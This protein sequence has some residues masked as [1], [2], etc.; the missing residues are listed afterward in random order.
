[1]SVVAERR[2]GRPAQ[3]S[4]LRDGGARARHLAAIIEG[5]IIP[6][7]LLAHGAPGTASTALERTNQR[8]LNIGEA[9][10]ARVADLSVAADAAP[11]LAYI[12]ELVARGLRAP[13][14]FVELI[15]PAARVLGRGWDVDRFDFVEVTLGLWRLQETVRRHAGPG[16]CGGGGGRSI[17]IAS[18]PGEQHSLGAIML[19]E[20]FTRGG[21]DTSLMIDARRAGLLAH[22]STR[23][24]DV[25]ALSVT[26][27]E[28]LPTLGA[29]IAALRQVTRLADVRVIAGGCALAGRDAFA[30][31]A[32]ADATSADA[33]GAVAAAERLVVARL[34][35]N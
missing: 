34:G 28:H 15:A 22:A 21:W 2:S 4:T 23:P 3:G 12:D 8:P 17:L 9:E 5:N 11:Y 14:L 7:L 33:E 30:L 19:D 10:V 13:R 26:C 20:A 6:R 1:M 32:G 29:T 27:L 18:Y 31:D 35:T 25:I 16:P 24:F